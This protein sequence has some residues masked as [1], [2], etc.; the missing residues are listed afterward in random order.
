MF[1]PK[2]LGLPGVELDL[3]IIDTAGIKDAREELFQ[4]WVEH[5]HG[6]W[7]SFLSSFAPLLSAQGLTTSLGLVFVYDITNRESFREVQDL[8]EEST[9][10]RKEQIPCML[11]G[12]KLDLGA[13]RQIS[14]AE[15][16][17]LASQWSAGTNLLTAYSLSS[18]SPA[19]N[20]LSLLLCSFL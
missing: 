7:S 1:S 19:V 6:T 16:H 13:K 9:R 17:E 14:S 5:A 2:D 8:H 4:E 18:S 12:N 10:S 3:D 15:G 20:A 11:I